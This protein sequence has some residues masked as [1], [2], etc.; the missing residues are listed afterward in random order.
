LTDFQP[1][2]VSGE[3]IVMW[4]QRRDKTSRD[5]GN[6]HASKDSGNEH[7]PAHHP[8]PDFNAFKFH[9]CLNI[10]SMIGEG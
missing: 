4:D 3:I 6:E 5:S 9:A 7:D 10:M 1:N 8:T 2:A